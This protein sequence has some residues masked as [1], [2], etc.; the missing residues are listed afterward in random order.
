MLCALT[1]DFSFLP[2]VGSLWKHF[3]RVQRVFFKY[4]TTAPAFVLAAIAYTLHAYALEGLHKALGRINSLPGESDGGGGFFIH[5]A[6]G[7][8]GSLWF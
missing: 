4:C 7:G 6:C 1:S 5:V 8:G 3:C 2:N